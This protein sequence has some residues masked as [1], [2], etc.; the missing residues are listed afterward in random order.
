MP[1]RRLV[2]AVLLASASLLGLAGCAGLNRIDSTV[3]SHSQWPAG[4]APGSY[5]FERLPSQQAQPAMQEML[6]AAARDALA[7]AGFAE[8]GD[9]ASADVNV[10]VGAR[11]QRYDPSPWADPFWYRWGWGWPRYG[12]WGPPPMMMDSPRYEREVALLMRDR[13]TG[14]VLY[15]TR[16]ANES[17]SAG[18][19]A[20][21]AAMFAA[22]LKDFPQ[23]AVNPRRVSIPL[24]R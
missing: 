6:E 15:E 5:V 24:E 23:P 9:A 8:A 4:R 10:Q 22:A 17:L 16:A 21:Y 18:D 11:L 3:S 13:R 12:W 14:Q 1:T 7:H 2:F 20:T 19:G